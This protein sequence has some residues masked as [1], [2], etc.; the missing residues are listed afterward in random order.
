MDKAR[1]EDLMKKGYIPRV[2][3]EEDRIALA[4]KTEKELVKLGYITQVGFDGLDETVEEEVPAVV[5]PEV[6]PVVEPVVEP[7]V[8]PE[9]E[10][11][12]DEGEE[13]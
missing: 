1:L 7:E 13:E 12:I 6:E 8:E 4:T 9:V 2:I 10:P 5:E 3:S 11:V